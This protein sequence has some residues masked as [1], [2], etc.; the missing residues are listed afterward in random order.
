VN[1]GFT[2]HFKVTGLEPAQ[3]CNSPVYAAMFHD[4]CSMSCAF[5]IPY[6]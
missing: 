5:T 4:T 2:Y 6:L 3:K 1:D